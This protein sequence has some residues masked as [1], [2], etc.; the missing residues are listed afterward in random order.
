M[1]K[2]TFNIPIGGVWTQIQFQ[3]KVSEVKDLESTLATKLGTDSTNILSSDSKFLLSCFPDT[4]IGQS[5]Y[6]GR[7]THLVYSSGIDTEKVRVAWNEDAKTLIIEFFRRKGHDDNFISAFENSV[8]S[9]T[10]YLYNSSNKEGETIYDA[11]APYF[12]LGYNDCPPFFFLVDGSYGTNGELTN[13]FCNLKWADDDWCVPTSDGWSQITSLDTVTSV[14]GQIS[15]DVYTYGGNISDNNNF[16]AGN[17]YFNNY[18]TWFPEYKTTTTINVEPDSNKDTMVICIKDGIKSNITGDSFSQQTGAD[19][20]SWDIIK[21]NLETYFFPTS[22]GDK[23]LTKSFWVP[24]VPTGVSSNNF[25]TVYQGFAAWIDRI[26]VAIN[27]PITNS[28]TSTHAIE[29]TSSGGLVEVRGPGR[30]VAVIATAIGGED[31]I[32]NAAS[33]EQSPP[34]IND[35]NKAEG[36]KFYIQ[37]TEQIDPIK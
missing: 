35:V 20:M 33:I 4:V 22:G 32:W 29:S 26:K 16:Y 18:Y 17:F 6:G 30:G 12:Y 5:V 11:S 37:F 3:T 9:N 14:N 7:C 8:I 28:I 13:G 21:G 2:A 34:N 10:C 31:G 23:I 24:N 25:D 27:N 36:F 19:G 15:S 1:S